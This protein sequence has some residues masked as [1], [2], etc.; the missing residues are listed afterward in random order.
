MTR[1]LLLLPLL[2]APLAQA[3]SAR[4]ECLGRVAFDVQEDIEWA[5]FSNKRVTQISNAKGGGH[6][7]TDKVAGRWERGSYGSEHEAVVYVTAPTTREEFDSAAIYIRGRGEIYKNTLL[8]DIKIH[9]RRIERF[10]QDP[11][12]TSQSI[13]NVEEEIRE[14]EADIP[15]TKI[16][17]HDLGIPDSYALGGKNIPFHLLLWRDSRVYYFAFKPYPGTAAYMQDLARRFRTRALY[18]VPQEPGIC[19][20]YGFIADDG[21]TAYELRNALRFTR[22]PNVIVSLLTASAGDPTEP[23]MGL[24]DTDYWPGFDSSKWRRVNLVE[25]VYFGKRLATFTGWHLTPTEGGGEQERAWFGHAHIGGPGT[26]TPMLA[27]Q[28][29]TFEKGI[30]DLIEHTPPPETV[31]PRIK[32]LTRSLHYRE[33]IA[34]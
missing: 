20:P 7:F 23:T 26:S 11:W 8:N 21:K 1:L 9:Q 5:V 13:K 14:I 17:D 19:F 18:E 24:Y 29:Q 15:L 28:V 27:I 2:L 34:R 3:D 30:D 22:T 32:A 4:Q 31:L 10:K 12:D 25:Q 33:G 6:R 16:Y